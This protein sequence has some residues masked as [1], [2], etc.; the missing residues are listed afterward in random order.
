[1][2]LSVINEIFDTAF[3]SI[4]LS[5]MIHICCWDSRMLLQLMFQVLTAA[6]MKVVAFWVVT[7]R[8]VV[9][10]YLMMEAASTSEPLAA[11]CHTTQPNNPEDGHLHRSKC[12]SVVSRGLVLDLAFFIKCC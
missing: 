8:S 9:E 11:F 10:V 4:V 7:P 3:A 6:S 2:L 1:M 5:I 12:S